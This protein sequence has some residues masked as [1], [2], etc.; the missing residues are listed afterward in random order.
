MSIWSDIHKRSNGKT[1]RKED[2]ISL[3][4]EPLK[5]D[6]TS[7]VITY[8]GNINK[9]SPLPQQHTLGRLYIVTEDCSY[10]GRNFYKGDVVVDTGN[11]WQTFANNVNNTIGNYNL[12]DNV[13]VCQ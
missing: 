10:Y 1:V 12:T 2:E 3:N 8:V 5:S 6:L 4:A 9:T 11:D 7:T 13:T